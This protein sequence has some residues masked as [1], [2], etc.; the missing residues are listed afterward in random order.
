[1]KDLFTSAQYIFSATKDFSSPHHILGEIAISG[2]S[3]VGKSSL[4]NHLTKTKIAKIS[5]TPGKTQ[6]MNIFLLNKPYYLVDLPGYGYAKVPQKMKNNWATWINSYLNQSNKIVLLLQL[7]DARH[8]P[9]KEDIAMLKWAQDKQLKVF[10]I[11]T[12]IDKIQKT[13]QKR[14][15]GN[16]INSLSDFDFS[17]FPYSIKDQ[18]CRK[19]LLLEIEQLLE[20]N[21]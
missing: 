5:T 18:K 20:K 4:I 2:K 17:Y 1:M 13:K 8:L 10:V 16:L 19:M 11:F 14:Q 21:K 12:K 6:T 7:I 9:T 15:V 3:N